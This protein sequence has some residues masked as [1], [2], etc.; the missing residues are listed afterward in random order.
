M[1]HL[2]TP[3]L[4]TSVLSVQVTASP[5]NLQ[6]PLPPQ[7]LQQISL[8]FRV[9]VKCRHIQVA[10]NNT[11]I[12]FTAHRYRRLPFPICQLPLAVI[13]RDNNPALQNCLSVHF[14]DYSEL[15][16]VKKVAD[17]IKRKWI[18]I[19]VREDLN[20][21]GRV[22]RLTVTLKVWN[23]G[24]FYNGRVEDGVMSCDRSRGIEMMLMR[25]RFE[26]IESD[27]VCVICL[28]ELER[29]KK[30]LVGM[31]CFHVFHRNCIVKWL[32]DTNSCPV[33]RFQMPKAP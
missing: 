15:V 21:F 8:K 1:E 33:C 24:M 6:Q 31:P 16:D 27:D 22:F 7:T 3:R 28:E 23:V 17:E 11:V 9:E 26:E 2:G 10:N 19:R 12:S 18:E 32:A 5:P 20:A 14:D 29:R 4:T 25:V 13:D 30:S